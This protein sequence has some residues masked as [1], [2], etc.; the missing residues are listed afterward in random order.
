M[1]FKPSI[2]RLED[3]WGSSLEFGI[4]ILIW[5]SPMIFDTV[6]FQILAIYFE[7]EGA[8]IIHVP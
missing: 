4:L 3:A 7:F 1:Y 2:E 5:I 6:L 8:K